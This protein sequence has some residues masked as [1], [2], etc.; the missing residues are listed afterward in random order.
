[1]RQ[2]IALA[3]LAG[4]A[5]CAAPTAERQPAS[6]HAV[7][8]SA[9]PQT[10]KQPGFDDALAAARMRYEMR[11]SENGKIPHDALMKAKAQRDAMIAHLGGGR[12]PQ[13]PSSRLG[14]TSPDAGTWTWIGPG[15]IGGRLRGIV[16]HPADP[17]VMWVGSASGGIW[18][19]TNGG[20]S[21]APLDDFLPSLAVGC[22]VRD[23][24]NP[25]I[26]YCGSGEGFFETEE[27]TSNTAAIRGAGI[28]KTID[29]GGTW[30]QIASTANSPDWYFVNRLSFE[31]GSSQ[32]M[33][34]ATSTG[35]WRSTNAGGAWNR[36][37]PVAPNPPVHY[38]DVKF[39]P[40]DPSRAV[41][42]GHDIPPQYSTN[43]GGAW[44]NATG[45]ATP[46]HRS[47]VVYAPSDPNT[48]YAAVAIGNT[49]RIWRSTNGGQSYL[50]QTANNG[51]SSLNPYTG[52]LWVDPLNVNH[53]ILG[54]QQYYRSTNAG[55]NLTQTYTAV[56]ADHHVI[57][58]H[59]G[60]NGTTNK[61]LFFG[62][63]GGIY[64]T[65]DSAG[66][67]A[68][69]LNNNLGVT[70]FYGAAVNDTSGVVIAGAQDNGTNRYNGNPQAWA[71]VI[72]GDGAYCAADPTD[73]NYFYGATQ[74]HAIRRS[75]NGG[76]SYT[77]VN[78]GLSDANSL[79]CNFI[80]YFLL[81]PN[82]PNRMLAAARRI[83]RSNNIKTGS[84]PVWTIIRPSIESVEPPPLPSRD[85]PPDHYLQN[86]EFNA[87]TIAIAQGN[88]NIIWVGY[89]GGQ[90][91][92]TA[93]GTNSN[94]TWVVVDPQAPQTGGQLPDRWIS[95]IV[96]DPSNHQRVYVSI[97]GYASNNVWMTSNDGGSWT[98]ISGSGVTGLPDVPVQAL[99]LHPT[100]PGR[101]YA[102]TDLGLFVTSDNGAT[103]APELPG[104]GAAPVDELVWR[105]ST[106]LMAVTH[107]RGVYFGV[108]EGAPCYPDCNNSGTLTVAD[109]GCFQ[110][111]FAAGNMYADCNQSGSLT[112]ADF[113]CF[114]AA[115]AA[116][117]P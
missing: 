70:Q 22:L 109:F 117:C 43:G 90:V 40:T 92:R 81:D 78:N 38:Y 79:N 53:L 12:G 49:L 41:A 18:K 34:A 35:L 102:G 96:I 65:T 23:P 48:V 83:W 76:T 13:P 89:N 69:E 114:Q 26:L 17:N 115:F 84:P 24:N 47:E 87:S 31:P 80:P 113:A 64:R 59:P 57:T 46:P 56:H 14:S 105:N 99:A 86:S 97:M 63:D 44:Q 67:S 20:T 62:G 82:D 94:P 3:M 66:G 45:F 77:L 21:W 9:A 112:I 10:E 71:S 11:L 88:P 28:F 19:T 29:G 42:G 6:N 75:S 116:G 54:G 27:G 37:A 72:G 8:S 111:A 50:V 4:L 52:V 98:D 55:V 106:T 68:S 104:V 85:P 91:A 73:P 61:T 33:L 100:I 25:D 2:A 39:H 51:I 15:N 107:G 7:A 5:G 103:W 60:Y 16:V 74:R 30:E 1:M 32:V 36:V 58:P 108:I 101:L 95:R 93:N 110:S